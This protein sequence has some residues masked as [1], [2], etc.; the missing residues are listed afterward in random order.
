MFVDWGG[1]EREQ[2]HRTES[3]LLCTHELIPLWDFTHL[4]LGLAI[5]FDF[6]WEKTPARKCIGWKNIVKKI[7]YF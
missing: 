6:L 4:P 3:C 2:V 1:V 5:V 7:C